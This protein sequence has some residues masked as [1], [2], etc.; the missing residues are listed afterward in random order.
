MNTA[1]GAVHIELKG[2]SAE[3]HDASGAILTTS[4]V[5]ERVTACYAS[6]VGVRVDALT[7]RNLRDVL[8]GDAAAERMEIARRVAR[9]GVPER[10]HE[11]LGGTRVLTAYAAAAAT[12]GVC[13][14]VAVTTVC[15]CR[16]TVTA[17]SAPITGCM[18]TPAFGCWE[19][20]SS[21]ELIVLRLMA[22]E[23]SNEQIARAVHR[24]RRAVEWHTRN[25]LKK[26]GRETRLGV[27][28]DAV[29]ACIHLFSDEEWA[30]IVAAR[31]KRARIAS[32][33]QASPYGAAHGSEGA[34]AA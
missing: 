9:T 28:K 33:R 17:G 19:R 16:H 14:R 2:W 6:R 13:E 29:E 5:I 8:A 3:P 34:S 30:V 25:L 4:G 1:S 23:L 11:C 20:L 31:P 18:R 27:V 10:W 22:N 7:G 15:A 26:L 32:T 24:S 12:D 21:L